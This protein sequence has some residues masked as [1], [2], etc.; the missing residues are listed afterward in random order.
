MLFSNISKKLRMDTG[1]GMRNP[2]GHINGGPMGR[3]MGNPGE[4]INPM[5]RQ[6]LHGN[7]NIGMPM[8]MDGPPMPSS[9]I[10]SILQVLH[11]RY[12]YPIAYTITLKAYF[13]GRLSPDCF[14]NLNSK[15]RLKKPFDKILH[16]PTASSTLGN[17]CQV[18]G[19]VKMVLGHFL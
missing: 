13:Y 15:N 18:E 11:T 6:R 7:M 3:M 4:H 10:N 5:N 17:L 16:R 1:R 14:F 2:P 12:N 19:S 9:A 8:H